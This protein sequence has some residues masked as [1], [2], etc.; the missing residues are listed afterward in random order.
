M[1]TTPLLILVRPEGQSKH[2]LRECEAEIGSS[3][4]AVISPIMEI[5]PA[6]EHPDLAPYKGVILTSVSAVR[7]AKGLAGKRLYCVG[8]RTETAGRKAGGTVVLTA[9]NSE[10]LVR[11]I[12]I[13]KPSGPLI[14]LRGDHVAGDAAKELSQGG[15]ETDFYEV[16]HQKA[17]PVGIAARQAISGSMRAVLPLYSPRSAH[18]LGQGV[19]GLGA[20][21]HVIAM[22]PA[23]AQVWQ[24]ETGGTCEICEQP[25]GGEMRARIVAAL[26]A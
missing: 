8:K 19:E 11:C 6:G 25:D 21:L 17:R 3:I 13:Q 12:L 15:I 7:H 10:E 2:L 16:Y 5:T 14:H 18:L 4:A 20:G 9:K 23:V 1:V 22:S 26:R 24:E